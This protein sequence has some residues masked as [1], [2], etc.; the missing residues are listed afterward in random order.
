MRSELNSRH[1]RNNDSYK[2][3][4]QTVHTALWHGKSVGKRGV[5]AIDGDCCNHSTVY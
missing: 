1:W 5:P 2:R 4:K 3:I